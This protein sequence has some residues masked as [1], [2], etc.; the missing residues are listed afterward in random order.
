MRKVDESAEPVLIP[1]AI[2]NDRWYESLFG[3]LPPLLPLGNPARNTN[4]RNRWKS[5][6]FRRLV[7]ELALAVTPQ[8]TPGEERMGVIQRLAVVVQPTPLTRLGDHKLQVHP[9]LA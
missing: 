3:A 4:R 8:A 1:P 9:V 6:R 7:S 5:Q 2:K